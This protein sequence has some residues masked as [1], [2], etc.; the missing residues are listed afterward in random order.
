MKEFRNRWH[1]ILGEI[2]W[3]GAWIM[4]SWRRLPG[5]RKMSATGAEVRYHQGKLKGT[6]VVLGDIVELVVPVSHWDVLGESPDDEQDIR[7]GPG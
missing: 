1:A 5:A 7:M 6:A 4:N 3:F 2:G